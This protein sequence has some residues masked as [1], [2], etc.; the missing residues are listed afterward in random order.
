MG[1]NQNDTVVPVSRGTTPK[2]AR[3]RT[4]SRIRGTVGRWRVDD[5]QCHRLSRPKAYFLLVQAERLWLPYTRCTRVGRS[6][7]D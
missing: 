4:P 5:T 7:I 1:M 2:G 3:I 6:N